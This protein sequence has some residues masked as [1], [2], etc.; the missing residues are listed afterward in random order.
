MVAAAGNGTRSDVAE[1]A[2]GASLS[3]RDKE[4]QK[5][6]ARAKKEKKK[7]GSYLL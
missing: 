3:K 2:V 7:K 4:D 6:V 1:V 5:P